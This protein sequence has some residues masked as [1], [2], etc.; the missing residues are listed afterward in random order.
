VRVIVQ[1]ETPHAMDRL[2]EI[3][4]VPGVDS[5]FMGPGD[6]SGA[7]GHVG[8]LMHPEVLAVMADAAKRCHQLGKPIGTVGGT[9][10]AVATY[11]AMGYDYLACASDLGLLMRNCASILSV[12]RTQDVKIHSQGY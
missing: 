9:P 1:I 11:R 12:I 10:D 5:I 6:L 4:S 8:N 7:M 2:E 3:A